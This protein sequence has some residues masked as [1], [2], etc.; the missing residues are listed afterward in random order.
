MAEAEAS[1]SSGELVELAAVIVRAYVGNDTV[2]S[3]DL[4]RIITDVHGALTKLYQ[5]TDF[6]PEKLAPAVSIRKSI[7]PDF[8]I[9]L[10]DGRHYK[11][12]K[13]NLSGHGLTPEQYREKWGLPRDY[14]MVAPNYA[15]KRS[16]LAKALGLGRKREPEPVKPK[17]AGR[18]TGA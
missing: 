3:A 1:I 17:R 6:T 9:S 16:E 13:R 18:G 2:P 4:P 7:S 14:P 15:K 10:E 5:V 12:L 11:S 8:L